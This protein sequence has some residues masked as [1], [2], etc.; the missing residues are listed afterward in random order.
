MTHE[1]QASIPARAVLARAKTFFAERIPNNAAYPEKEGPS[2]LTLRGQGGE[3]IAISVMSVATGT[4]IR[5]STLLFDQ[6]LDRFLS[7]L[8][9]AGEGAA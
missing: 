5:A 6:A 4:K 2:F 9:A 1:Y 3:E 8:P 7:T